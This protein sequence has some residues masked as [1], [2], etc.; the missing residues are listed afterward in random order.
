MRT[1][2]GQYL[3]LLE[4]RHDSQ[5][6]P[7]QRLN[8]IIDAFLIKVLDL[9]LIALIDIV[10]HGVDELFQER[11]REGLLEQSMELPERGHDSS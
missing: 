10:N 7:P 11:L 6:E 3:I 8:N 9:L 2:Y 4:G 1:K 5:R